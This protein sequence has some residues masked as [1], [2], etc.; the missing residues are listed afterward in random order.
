MAGTIK[1]ITTRKHFRRTEG[2]DL[3]TNERFEIEDNEQGQK[4]AS[5]LIKRGKAVR[6]SSKLEAEP[7][8]AKPQL[9]T[10]VMRAEAAPQEVTPPPRAPQ[11]TLLD[12]THAE[13]QA[14]AEHDARARRTEGSTAVEPMM[15]E[16]SPLVP[17]QRRR[18]QRRDMTPQ[19]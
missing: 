16:D 11:P 19:E 10:R 14:G 3:E 5:M 7:V 4:E 12:Q 15:T 9:Q 6:D 17:H 2:R 13:Q 1:M 18:Y 8:K